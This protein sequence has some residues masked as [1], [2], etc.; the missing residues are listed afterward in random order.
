TAAGQGAGDHWHRPQGGFRIDYAPSAADML[1]LQGDAYTGS[2]AVP[3]SLNQKI[4]G[5]NLTGRWSHTLRDG[6]ALQ[7][8]AY[9]DRTDRGEVAD[10]GSF[11]LDTYDLDLQHSF[12]LGSNNTLV[13]GAGGRFTHSQ[14]HPHGA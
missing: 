10:A 4:S 1:T 5:R 12:S 13:W 2:E 6:G 3:G 14:I 7:L 8:Q 9:Y 11:W